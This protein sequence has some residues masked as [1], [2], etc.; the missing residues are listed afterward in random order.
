MSAIKLLA[1]G[2]FLYLV[3]DAISIGAFKKKLPISVISLIAGS[4]NPKPT[5]EGESNTGLGDG[6]DSW[7]FDKI[8]N[9]TN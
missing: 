7:E 8:F 9:F 6:L 5:L 2:I 1:F 4:N 3:A